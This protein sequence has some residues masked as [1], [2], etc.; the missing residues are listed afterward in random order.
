M[1]TT[2]ELPDG[3]LAEARR[4]AKREGTT[5]KALIEQGLR[6]TLDDRKARRPF[7]LQDASVDGQGL[8]PDLAEAGWDALRDLAYTGRGT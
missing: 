7:T 8:A 1:K 6:R 2:I 3:L 5:L 4:L